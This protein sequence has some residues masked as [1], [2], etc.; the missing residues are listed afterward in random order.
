MAAKME[1]AN[2]F[3]WDEEQCKREMGENTQFCCGIG[4][5]KATQLWPA[6][7]VFAILQQALEM[8]SVQVY[9][10]TK[11]VR[12]RAHEEDGYVVEYE[13]E[14]QGGE[15][16]TERGE[17]RC[18]KV[19]YAVNAWIPTLLPNYKNV[20]TPVKGQVL[21][22]SPVS[23]PLVL[24]GQSLG[25]GFVLS[26]HGLNAVKKGMQ[27]VQKEEEEKDDKHKEDERKEEKGIEGENAEEVDDQLFYVIRRKKDGRVVVGS[28]VRRKK[29]E[30][31]EM[32]N[33]REPHPEVTKEMED[34]LETFPSLKRREDGT[35]EWEVEY[36]WQ[37][38][39]GFTEDDFPLVGPLGD[40]K[41]EE[42]DKERQDEKKESGRY[43]LGGFNGDG[44]PKCF[45][46]GKVIAEMIV[47]KLLPEDFLASFSPCRFLK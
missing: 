3:W 12:E 41:D 25:L 46:S 9:T 1:E 17:L 27:E 14:S 15:G 5:E 8:G 33:D 39:M 18:N 35:R 24:G 7:L 31:E 10:Q 43:I 19:V 32:Y 16:E 40:Q 20:V 30:T 13:M 38:V 47:G 44:M 36:V 6:K 37:G 22:T 42:R 4:Q 23:Q 2:M 21:V 29:G 34:F 26:D 28:R 45:G 11:V